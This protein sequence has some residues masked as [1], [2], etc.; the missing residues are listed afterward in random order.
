MFKIIVC[1][2]A[3]RLA[4]VGI[5]FVLLVKHGAHE[6]FRHILQQNTQFIQI[7]FLIDQRQKLSVQLINTVRIGAAVQRH[8]GQQGGQFDGPDPHG[9]RFT[10]LAEQYITDQFVE[11]ALHFRYAA[12][13]HLGQQFLLLFM[14]E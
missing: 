4:D 5:A 13:T 2:K 1:N 10:A 14:E 8:P 3:Q 12:G 9:F 11:Q 6:S 7:L